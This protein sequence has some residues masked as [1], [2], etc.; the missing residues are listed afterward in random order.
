MMEVAALVVLG[1]LLLALRKERPGVPKQDA[2]TVQQHNRQ[3]Q[4]NR[5]S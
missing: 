5:H 3:Q 1:A 2:Q 4:S